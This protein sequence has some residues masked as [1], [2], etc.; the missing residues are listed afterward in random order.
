MRSM[1]TVRRTGIHAGMQ[2][3]VAHLAFVALFGIAAHGGELALRLQPTKQAFRA[4]DPI[5][6][7]MVLTNMTPRALRLEFAYPQL[8][9]AFTCD[10]KS[11]VPRHRE[12][13]GEGLRLF[14]GP[15]PT[16]TLPPHSKYEVVFALK[17]YLAFRQP[18][19][20]RVR[21]EAFYRDIAD[22]RTRQNVTHRPSGSFIV[23]VEPGPTTQDE[24]NR[25]R[26]ALLSALE[27]LDPKRVA[28]SVELLCWVDD[29]RIIPSLELAAARFYPAGHDI[30]EALGRFAPGERATAALLTAA[31]AVDSSALS[32]VFRSCSARGIQIP[33]DVYRNLLSSKSRNKRWLTLKHL[34]EHEDPRHL[35][36]VMSL[37]SDPDPQVA[38]LARTLARRLQSKS[39][40]PS[41]SRGP[42]SLHQ[43][44]VRLVD[45]GCQTCDSE[46][47]VARLAGEHLKLLEHFDSPEAKREVYAN[48]AE[49]YV[50]A[51]EYN[52]DHAD[53]AA[54][55]FKKAFQY[56][57]M[58]ILGAC[59][60]YRLWSRALVSDYY[61]RGEEEYAAAR[62]RAIIPCL[63]GLKLVLDNRIVG[64]IEGLPPVAH[65]WPRPQTPEEW[66]AYR[67]RFYRECQRRNAGVQRMLEVYRGELL[68]L[69]T[70]LYADRPHDDDELQQFA[71]DILLDGAAVRGLMAKL[72]DSK[73]ELLRSQQEQL[74]WGIDPRVVEAP[75]VTARAAPGQTQSLHLPPTAAGPPSP[76]RSASHGV[77]APAEAGPTT[78]EPVYIWTSMAV[79][80]SGVL[81]G[82]G[83]GLAFCNRR[84]RRR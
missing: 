36:A 62:R 54:E 46:E 57:G 27:E 80:G 55:F 40:D 56:P 14:I 52:P 5:E 70:S 16:T 13:H 32:V 1:L 11:A 72:H 47:D 42:D 53:R 83:L 61:H 48:L 50:A 39:P 77:A 8:G 64:S 84:Q 19:L 68:E 26:Q 33:P 43:L 76:T 60:R 28:Q 34:A 7:R 69:A 23:R 2:R 63:R 71:R 35:A 15:V 17:R 31:K 6:V 20:Y 10:D 81:L 51:T 65:D 44:A 41:N 74:K 12:V 66:D 21:Y 79:A 30:V 38:E 58:D 9:I 78:R 82:F 45:L 25:Y 59:R 67:D 3:P 75:P 37:R 29:P 18:K 73:T 49:L 22:T 24:I 4:T